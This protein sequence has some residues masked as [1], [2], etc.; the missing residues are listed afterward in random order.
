MEKMKY[1]LYS[2]LLAICLYSCSSTDDYEQEPQPP[3]EI[4]D[5]DE[6]ASI[7]VGLVTYYTFD[8]ETGDDSSPNH[9]DAALINRPDMISDTPSNKGK[10]VYLRQVEKQYINIPY[11]LFKNTTYSASMWIKDFGAGIL[12]SAVN[13]DKALDYPCF[14]TRTSSGKFELYS[15]NRGKPS[16]SYSF[17][18]PFSSLQDEKWHMV[19]FTH[20]PNG[21]GS[22]CEK[23]LYVDGKLVANCEGVYDIPT[24]IK[25]QTGGDCDGHYTSSS[26][27]MKLDNIRIYDRVLEAE[28]INTIY[29]I[30]RIQ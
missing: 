7:G 22:S 15:N 1:Y 8:D 20:I 16:L 18:Y 13:M 14:A 19:A 4:P 23:K 24:S 12:L 28:E 17:S 27:D 3:I 11:Q 29:N 25:V 9:Y 6:L 2:V 21:D 5:A 10:A 26:A 30:E